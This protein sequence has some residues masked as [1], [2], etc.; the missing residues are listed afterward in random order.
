LNTILNN[1]LHQS[2]LSKIEKF[3]V[4]PAELLLSL[5]LSSLAVQRAKERTLSLLLLLPIFWMIGAVLG[6]YAP[7]I[8]ILNLVTTPGLEII[9]KN[10]SLLLAIGLIAVGSLVALEKKMSKIW[11]QVFVIVE[12]IFSG[13][14]NGLLLSGHPGG[15][16]GLAG[17][18]VMIWLFVFFTV[19]LLKKV[20]TPWINLAIRIGGSWI[21]AAGLLL[22]GFL[23][24]YPQ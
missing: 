8:V 3:W 11:F 21:S 9:G 18:T 20:S 6:F 12:G 10:P 1:E 24:K 5:G 23:L 16:N 13:L 22:F 17:E 7:P 2:E 14:I 4:E 19:L 15:I